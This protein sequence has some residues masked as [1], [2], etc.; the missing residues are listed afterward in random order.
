MKRRTASRLLLLFLCAA[1]VCAL[2]APCSAAKSAGETRV[3][4]VGWYESGDEDDPAAYTGAHGYDHEYLQALSQYAGWTY[5]YVPGTWEECLS[6]LESG[7]I[8][9]LGFVSKTDERMQTLA[10]SSLPMANT[11]VWLVV[12]DAGEIKTADKASLQGVSVGIVAG[13]AYNR[14]FEEYC[15]QIGCTVNYVEFDSFTDLSPALKDGSISAAIL[16]DEDITP[17]EKA[18]VRLA[19]SSRY[20]AANINNT[21]L[22]REL[23]NAL[24]QVSVFLPNLNSDLYQKYF[25]L[26]VYGKPVFTAAEQEF[27]RN[28]PNILVKYDSGW[29]PIEYY[30]E[31]T[32]DYAGISP[33][34]FQLLSEKCGINFVYEG[35]TSRQVLADLQGDGSDN[36]LTT[37]SYDYAWA[38]QHNVYI[39]Q[40]FI[41][42]SIVRLGKNVEAE[43][44]TVAINDKAYFTYLLQ[45]ELRSANTLSFAKQAERLE[46]VRTGVAD[47]TYVTEDQ[48]NYYR[49]IPKYRDLQVKK[50]A[51][52]EQSICI[53]VTK[54]S[55]PALFTIL[56]KALASVSHDEMMSIVMRNT[57]NSYKVTFGD[58]LYQYRVP[59]I[60]ILFLLSAVIVSLSFMV[61]VRRKSE[62]ELQVAYQQEQAAHELER[63]ALAAAEKASTAK[64]NFM[65]RI[66]HEI[67][68]P[69]NA[70][71]GYNTIARNE[72]SDSDNPADRRQADMKVLDCLTKCEIASKHLLTIINDVLDMSAIES[73]K[74]H[75]AH[76][77]FDFKGLIGSL[78]S[79]FYS[80]AKN[81][82][83]E[84]E[85]LFDTMTEEWFVGDQMRVN[86]VLTNLLSNAIKFTP[87]GGSV[88]LTICQPEAQVNAAHI[89]FEV[90][91]TGIGMSQEYLAHIWTPF[92]QADSSISRRFGGTGLGLSIT[93]NLI[94][95][96]GGTI[97]VRSEL[98]VGSTFSVD[99]TFERTEQPAV[100]KTYDFSSIN[101]LIVDDDV[102]TCDYVRLLFSRCGARCSTVTSG[103]DALAAF[104]ESVKS[105][106]PYTVC[107][108]DWRMP[109]MD[110]IE[111]VKRIRRISGSD[112]PIII[113]TAY[114]FTEVVDAARDV[115]VNMFISKPLFQS[116]LFDLLA[117]ISGEHPVSKMG[118]SV[119]Y[120]F[121]GARVLLAE[122]NAMNL[123]IAK[124]ILE[125]VG[126]TVDCAQNGRE[127][128]SM[129]C[130]AP[131]ETYQA[132][133]MD[134]QMPEMDGHEATRTIRASTHPEA[135]TIPIIAMT[136][137]AFAENVAEALAAGMNDHVSKPIDMNKLFVTLS[138]YIHNQI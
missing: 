31:Q 24:I 119:E 89:H 59:T 7:E 16:S 123:E 63:Q 87:E 83:V 92:E 66:S 134:V 113:I 39:T 52:Y 12:G 36:V 14:Y 110:G 82:N 91:D 84:F 109:Q 18:L 47:Y 3:I 42:S 106:H 15:K 128:V 100:S 45:D 61:G 20:Y 130:D 137:D 107:M 17:S 65:S 94:D 26:N 21:E 95:L 133:L 79:I 115:G 120:N 85:V 75:V 70:V 54:N 135:A 22:L 57:V 13:S 41:T 80:Q 127:A 74:I 104:S 88:K 50:M 43:T 11:N 4:R 27:I 40:P 34:L 44:P 117:N 126:L 28:H 29:P 72:M 69:L 6:R 121:S 38:E 97:T 102:S 138:K 131:A 5:E 108:V 48:A 114:D 132:V 96:M 124:K 60:I 76:D 33:A 90:T 67:R 10:Y 129:F 77:R 98:G 2:T 136:A 8:D 37:I 56:S 101:A 125:S 46:A 105:G 58:L 9:L 30:D 122:D 93:K 62:R 111:T 19:S 112:L 35:S 116:S 1:A 55:D 49:S 118:R 71:I 78:T 25:S 53:S 64:G 81:K 86:Q 51:G 99:L 32:G 23:D 73:G 68:T 103:A